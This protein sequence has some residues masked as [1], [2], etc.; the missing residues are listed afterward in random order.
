MAVEVHH[1]GHL[2]VSEMVHHHV[3]WNRAML[4]MATVV[5][6]IVEIMTM[7]VIHAIGDTQGRIR[8]QL[9]QQC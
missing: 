5:V 8:T 1:P 7:H 9:F 2:D 4:T 3:E 6:V